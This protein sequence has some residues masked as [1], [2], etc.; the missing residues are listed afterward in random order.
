MCGG[1]QVVTV[2][3]PI[4]SE[5]AASG[6]RSGDNS[7]PATPAARVG[8]AGP[9]PLLLPGPADQLPAEQRT[10]E[11]RT[12]EQRTAEKRTADSGVA[13]SGAAGQRTAEQRTAEQR[14]AE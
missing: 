10:A 11:Q 7:R 6:R 9:L 8:T 14:T 13:Y 4:A 1:G 2:R 12:A 3:P 5:E